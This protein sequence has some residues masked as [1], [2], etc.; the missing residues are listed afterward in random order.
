MWREIA[1]VGDCLDC[2]KPFS[3][4]FDLVA[5]HWKAPCPPSNNL[6]LHRI[7]T[8]ARKQGCNFVTIESA[9]AR[10]DVRDEIDALDKYC[11]GDGDAEA[12]EFSFFAGETSPAE[13]GTVAPNALVANVILINY[14]PKGA[15]AFQDTYIYEAIMIPPIWWT[16][17]ASRNNF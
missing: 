13:I 17:Q 8:L 15:N 3:F 4:F 1:T 5:K 16:S 7:C 6:T 14:H 10:A 11:G 12:I 2:R 9:L